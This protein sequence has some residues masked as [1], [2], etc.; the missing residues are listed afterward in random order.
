MSDADHKIPDSLPGTNEITIKPSALSKGK[1]AVT[2]RR[3]QVAG[4]ISNVMS[5]DHAAYG[6]RLFPDRP[7]QNTPPPHSPYAIAEFSEI[8]AVTKRP[9]EAQF[10]FMAQRMIG[11]FMTIAGVA[12]TLVMA[13]CAL[14]LIFYLISSASE[15]L[16]GANG[17]STDIRQ[18]LRGDAKDYFTYR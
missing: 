14:L 18:L 7:K 8:S 12:I 3:S 10:S 17:I 11:V 4:L 15:L 13:I 6:K 1:A 16:F 9:A 5:A 2:A